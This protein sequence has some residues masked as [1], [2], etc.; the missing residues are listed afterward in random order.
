MADSDQYN[1]IN[2][3]SNGINE[4]TTVEN[5]NEIPLWAIITTSVLS[6]LL[7]CTIIAFLILYFRERERS[8]TRERIERQFRMAETK[9]LTRYLQSLREKMMFRNN[10][11]MNAQPYPNYQNGFPVGGGPPGV[12]VQFHPPQSP[13]MFDQNQ[14][15]PPVQNLP[16]YPP[17]RP[18]NDPA[19]PFIPPS[20]PVQNVIPS[21]GHHSIQ[22]PNI[23]QPSFLPPQPTLTQGTISLKVHDP[24]LI[25]EGPPPI[26]PPGYVTVPIVLQSENHL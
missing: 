21:H 7:I 23:S 4:I 15:P 19:P 25:P 5:N 26:P 17:Q 12:P 3:A 2:P 24:S 8:K 22:P 16:P 20:V 14:I 6:C 9:K 11:Q 10:P 13:P 18:F 1:D